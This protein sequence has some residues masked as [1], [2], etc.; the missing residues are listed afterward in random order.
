LYIVK[1]LLV[2]IAEYIINRH[3]QII[4]LRIIGRIFK[5]ISLDS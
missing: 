3:Y 5:G 1:W 4:S 2:S